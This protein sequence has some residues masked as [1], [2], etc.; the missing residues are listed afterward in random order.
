M[1][2]EEEHKREGHKHLPPIRVHLL[3][4]VVLHFMQHT[5][6]RYMSG[7]ILWTPL[8]I[9]TLC[10]GVFF[11]LPKFLFSIIRLHFPCPGW[12]QGRSDGS[13]L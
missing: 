7:N 4:L 9:R 5:E 13:L 3:Y 11:T 2:E 8:G 1:R 12:G 10:K 6:F